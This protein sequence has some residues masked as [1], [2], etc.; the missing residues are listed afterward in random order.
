MKNNKV[1]KIVRFCGKDFLTCY[2]ITV[3]TQVIK[4]RF[5]CF[6]KTYVHKIY[7][8][9]YRGNVSFRHY[10]SGEKCSYDFENFLQKY[11]ELYKWG[12]FKNSET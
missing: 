11:I 10:P 4:R 3:E 7:Y 12:E 6:W 8:N 1:V 5:P 9:T 2:D